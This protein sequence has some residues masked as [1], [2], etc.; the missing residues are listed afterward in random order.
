[1]QIVHF[2]SLENPFIISFLFNC[3]RDNERM[4]ST[5]VPTGIQQNATKKTHQIFTL[6]KM[7][8]GRWSLEDD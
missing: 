3:Q 2:G 6:T 1:M 5:S 8:L 4:V 7:E